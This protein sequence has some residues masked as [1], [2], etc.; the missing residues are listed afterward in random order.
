MSE[1]GNAEVVQSFYANFL[2]G[3]IDAVLALLSPDF[4]LAYSG[5]SIIPA[6]GTWNGHEGFRSWA[7]TGFARSSAARVGEL[8]GIH[9]SR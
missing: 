3:H 7:Q 9:R 2:G 6:A 8:W 4:A 1:N 5:P